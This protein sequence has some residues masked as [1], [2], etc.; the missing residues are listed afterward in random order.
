MTKTTPRPSSRA[1]CASPRCTMCLPFAPTVDPDTGEKFCTNGC[2][3]ETNLLAHRAEMAKS[4]APS[5]AARITGD[6]TPGLY[7][8]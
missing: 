7:A 3:R 8:S 5:P 1:I 2:L 6:Q 4:T